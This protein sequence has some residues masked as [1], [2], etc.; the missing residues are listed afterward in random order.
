MAID[1]SESGAMTLHAA[2][3][4]TSSGVG[5]PRFTASTKACITKKSMPP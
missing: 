5:S 1:R 4:Y 3:S 2:A